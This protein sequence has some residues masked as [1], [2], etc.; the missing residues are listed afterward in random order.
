[1]A[2]LQTFFKILFGY[3]TIAGLVTFSMFICEEAF[4]TAMFGTWP[5]Q[6]AKDWRLIKK[7]LVIMQ[8]ANNTMKTINYIFGY[9]QPLAFFAYRSYGISGDYYIEALQSKVMANAPELFVGENITLTLRGK[10]YSIVN[11][12]R[13]YRLGRITVI[14]LNKDP[15][16]KIITGILEEKQNRLI[17]VMK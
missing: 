3:L 1:V 13:E 4:Q 6:D 7:G 9:I 8:A 2:K 5:A 12:F 11:G 15:T 14:T 16:E 10:G 17:M